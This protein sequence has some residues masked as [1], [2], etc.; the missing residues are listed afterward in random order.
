MVPTS[1]TE[2]PALPG[3]ASAKIVGTGCCCHPAM[4]PFH[5][6]SMYRFCLR[7]PSPV[8]CQKSMSE[9][10]KKQ[11]KQQSQ[12]QGNKVLWGGSGRCNPAFCMA[13]CTCPRGRMIAGKVLAPGGPSPSWAA[14]PSGMDGP[15]SYHLAGVAGLDFLANHPQVPQAIPAYP[16]SGRMDQSGRPGMQQPKCPI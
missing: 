4:S 12:T 10:P 7:F 16:S 1:Q 2:G 14:H 8:R 15:D 6:T 13:G 5:P 9:K 3:H 11:Q